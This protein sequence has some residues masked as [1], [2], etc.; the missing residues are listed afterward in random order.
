MRWWC[1]RYPF[2]ALTL[3]PN[4]HLAGE[5]QSAATPQAARIRARPPTDTSISNLAALALVRGGGPNP[6]LGRR[7]ALLGVT[8]P[9]QA[10]KHVLRWGQR[11]TNQVRTSMVSRDSL[12][13][14]CALCPGLFASQAVYASGGG[15]ARWSMAGDPGSTLRPAEA[16]AARLNNTPATSVRSCSMACR[17]TSEATISSTPT[18]TDEK[19]GVWP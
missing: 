14:P 11:G 13:S 15:H 6:T 8:L 17:H 3:N 2:G 19:D 16:S 12:M 1:E 10:N 5:Q 18:E 7:N 9:V 4:L